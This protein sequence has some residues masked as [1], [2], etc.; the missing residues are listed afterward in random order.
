MAPE[1]VMGRPLTRQSD[2]YSFGVLLFELLTGRK[3]VAGDTVEQIFH[4]IL[5]EPVILAPLRVLNLPEGVEE[6]IS[7][8][9]EKPPA[10]RPRSLGVVCEEI[11][12]ILDPSNDDPAKPRPPAQTLQP[13]P[14]AP[15]P[16]EKLPWLVAK[17]PAGLRSEPGLM[18]LAAGT[19]IVASMLVY[20]AVRI[21]S[22]R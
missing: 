14:S 11:E 7:R 13:R 2:V 12:H 22:T 1:Q 9:L 10:Q 21:I 19:V 8:C 17:L 18:L 5:Y 20:I 16:A 15:V 6:L 3:A 4:R